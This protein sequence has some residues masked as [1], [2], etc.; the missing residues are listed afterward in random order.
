MNI[1]GKLIKHLPLT[2]GEGKNGQWQKGGFVL[3][4]PNDKYPKQ[5]MFATWGDLVDTVSNITVGINVDVSFDVESREY[6]GKYFTDAKAWKVESI[7]SYAKVEPKVAT[8]APTKELSSDDD[9]PF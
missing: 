1:K 6:Q 2:T 4:V 8:K 3:E 7:D 5:I 9:L